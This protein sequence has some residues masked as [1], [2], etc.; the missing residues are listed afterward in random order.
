MS[1]PAIRV[2]DPH[3]AESVGKVISR[4]GAMTEEQLNWLIEWLDKQE[5]Y[6]YR[7]EYVGE[8]PV[9]VTSTKGSITEKFTDNYKD[10]EDT[11]NNIKKLES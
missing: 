6:E 9:L 2:G 8:Y 10:A 7:V 1:R 11:I 3:S 4:Y 5:N